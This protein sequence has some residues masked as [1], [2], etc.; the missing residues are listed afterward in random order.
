MRPSVWVERQETIKL[1]AASLNRLEVRSHNGFIDYAGKSPGEPE[2]IAQAAIKAGGRSDE[3][4]RE[5]LA[6]L[7]VVVEDAGAGV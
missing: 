5:A 7:E 3:D 6:N 1:D 4:A 2:I